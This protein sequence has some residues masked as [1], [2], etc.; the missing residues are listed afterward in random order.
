MF[1]EILK[2]YWH[3]GLQAR[4]NF[5]RDRDRREVHLLIERDTQIHPVEFKKTASPGRS[6]AGSFSALAKLGKP[7]GPGAVVCLKETDAKL[8]KDVIAIPAGL[9]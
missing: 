1:A 3:N 6:A 9:L 5:Y 4:F 7:L 8:A 2:S